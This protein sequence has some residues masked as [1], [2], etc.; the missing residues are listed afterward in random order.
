MKMSCHPSKKDLVEENHF[1]HV[2]EMVKNK[3]N[4]NSKNQGSFC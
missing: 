4:D 2:S 3:I 1:A